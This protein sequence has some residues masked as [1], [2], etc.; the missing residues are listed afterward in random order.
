[1][2]PASDRA[3]FLSYA[4]QDADAARRL[5]EALRAVGVEVWF[6]QNELV[7]GDAWDAK[8]RKQIA[9]C[10]LFVPLISASTQARREGY[11]RLEWRIAA[12]RTHMM[13]EQ[14]A[15]L[16]PVVIDATRDAEADVPAEFKAVQW[17]RLPGADA[18]ATFCARVKKLLTS[19]TG[20]AVTVQPSSGRPAHRPPLPLHRKPGLWVALACCLALVGYRL[21]KETPKDAPTASVPVPAAAA[22]LSEARQLVAKVWDLL[23]QPGRWR[24][25]LDTADLL[26]KRAASLDPSDAEVWAAWAQT[27][28]T[29]VWNLID[30]SAARRDAARDHAARALQLDP[31]SYEARLARAAYL[32]HGRSALESRPDSPEAEPLLRELLRERPGEPRAALELFVLVRTDEAFTL[33]ENVAKDHPA[34]AARALNE[35]AWRYFFAN[36]YADADAMADR[37]IAANPSAGSLGLKIVLAYFWHGDLD[38][39]KVTLQRM[40]TSEL[41]DDWG[42][43]LGFRVFT[44]R[45]EFADGLAALSAD[46]REWF[47]TGLFS[48]PKALL[49]AELRRRSGQAELARRDYLRALTQLDARLVGEP[50]DTALLAKKTEALFYLDRRPEADACYRL[51]LETG[52]PPPLNL[53]ILFESPEVALDALEGGV[54]GLT[55]NPIRLTAASLRLDPQY[56]PLRSHPR[57]AALLAQAEADPKRSPNAK[58]P[59]SDGQA[60]PQSATDP[61]SVAVLAFANLSDDKAN[62]F[63]SDGI[64]EELLNVLAK[65]P[66]LKV[67]ARTSSFHFKGMNT[68]IPEIAQQLGVAYVVEGSV[69]KSGSKVRITAQLIKAA[70]GFHVWSDTFTRDLK[71]IFAVQDEIAGLIAQN[72]SLKLGTAFAAPK[73]EINPEAYLALL[74]GRENFAKA[75]ISSLKASLADFQRATA[76]EPTYAVAW[77]QLAR[78][79]VQLA[80]WG[81]VPAGVGFD[82]ADEAVKKAVALEPDAPEVLV[83][84]GWVQ[85]TGRWDFRGAEQSFRRALQLRPDQADVVSSAAVLLFNVGKITEGIALAE[86][87]LQLDPLNAVAYVNLGSMLQASKDNERALRAFRSALQLAPTGQRYHALVAEMLADL[88]RFDEAEKEARAETD[89]V[90]RLFAFARIAMHRG[91]K[92][93]ALALVQKLEELETTHPGEADI[94][95]YAVRIYAN[96]G[97]N[98]RAF[99]VLEKAH[100]ARDPG[101]AWMKTE[102]DEQN[103]HSDPRWPVFL[104][105]VG[106]ADD[107]LLK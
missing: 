60:T 18:T 87:A 81:G 11:F 54:L 44:W 23:N 86:R 50:N 85:R 29:Y 21:L 66:G 80:R 43:F 20:P 35:L 68:A 101:I 16:L 106:L 46:P 25:E 53:Q 55:K 37:S 24:T 62:E 95:F 102:L 10:A 36:R 70:D 58:S 12:Q 89:E 96:L 30:A 57:F 91:D 38:L 63:F 90:G 61:K 99:A 33:L 7:G 84:L 39:A 105:K 41:Q 2:P 103:L 5:C 34:F 79:Y 97:E 47:S 82:A 49:T 48:G 93:Q 64:S 83:A 17:T 77:A 74:A 69:R 59:K 9:E 14:I 22:P 52:I 28:V 15:F 13:S 67:T 100:T 76:L 88:G 4:S 31:H 27:D 98:D 26:C 56:A 8:I 1:M 92:K 19:E 40:S 72:L 3:V 94:Y 6:D 104:R 107:Q 32:A 71:D 73:G 78:S 51:L 42:A 65:V 75:S 45:N